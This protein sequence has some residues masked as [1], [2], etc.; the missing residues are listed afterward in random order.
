MNERAKLLKVTAIITSFTT[1]LCLM[2][3]VAVC[4]KDGFVIYPFV[5]FLLAFVCCIRFWKMYV[6]EKKRLLQN[7]T[8]HK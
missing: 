8:T 3:I 6:D 1:I 2:F 7:T 5:G 4:V